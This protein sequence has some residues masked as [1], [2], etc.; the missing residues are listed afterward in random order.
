MSEDKIKIL[1]V[2]STLESCGPITQLF[3]IVKNLD[4]A[5]FEP[6][7][8]TLSPEPRHS[9]KK[10]FIENGIKVDSL[11]LSRL[12]FEVYG[13]SV[14]KKKIKHYKPDIIH[15]SG[16]RADVVI[17]KLKLRYP[18]CMTIHNYVFDDFISKFGIFIGNIASRY[19]LSAIKKCK[20]AICCSKTLQK[21]YYNLLNKKLYAIQNGVDISKF[22]PANNEDENKK[23]RLKLGIPED[24]IVFLVVGV[25]IERKDP[26]TIIKAFKEAN[27]D[28]KATLVLLGNGELFECCKNQ[29][30]KSII[31][32]GKVNNV[33]EYLKASDVYI[34][35]SKSEGLPYSVLEAGS[36]GLELILSNIP[37]HIEIFEKNPKLLKSFE[38]GNVEQLTLIIKEMANKEMLSDGEKIAK[39]IRNNFNDKLMSKNYENIYYK[40]LEEK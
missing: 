23:L 8:L 9:S 35:A 17:N 18:H 3:G 28:K 26:L 19:E 27:V 7:I 14:L 34:S 2:E 36:S 40:M 21:K 16:L 10:M 6:I 25:L 29:I 39:L 12:K 31:M 24:K 37:Q 13:K 4:R 5:K 15:S 20:Y 11:N 1:Y 30:D 22:F 32:K 33:E 38:V